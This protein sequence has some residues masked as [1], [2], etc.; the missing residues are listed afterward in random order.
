MQASSISNDVWA[1]L[2]GHSVGPWGMLSDR[3][4]PWRG[5]GTSEVGRPIYL[6]GGCDYPAK[7]LRGQR[8]AKPV[9]FSSSAQT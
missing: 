9:F 5:G 4:P 8:G 3:V 1:L 6:P 7:T 2:A